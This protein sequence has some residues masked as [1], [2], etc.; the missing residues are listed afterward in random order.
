MPGWLGGSRSSNRVSP[1]WSAAPGVCHRRARAAWQQGFRR[2][3]CGRHG[4]GGGGGHLLLPGR[5]SGFGAGGG[6]VRR[7]VA[8]V[9]AI[10]ALTAATAAAAAA[11]AQRPRR[12]FR[13]GSRGG[14]RG[15]GRGGSGSGGSGRGSGCGHS[16]W[17]GSPG[18]RVTALDG[19]A[20]LLDRRLGRL[21]R[22]GR[23]VARNTATG[24]A[25]GAGL[26]LAGVFRW[27]FRRTSTAAWLR[28]E[29]SRSGNHSQ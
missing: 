21:L 17:R 15:F 19:A 12:C 26:P 9:A 23:S 28:V 13:R 5:R 1:G 3:G 20:R 27:S 8:A 18:I 24:L 11:E 29:V 4:G 7:P 2:G 25:R 16:A 22:D 14:S 10:A 6:G